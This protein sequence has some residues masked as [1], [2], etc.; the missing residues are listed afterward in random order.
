[1]PEPINLNR[2]RKQ[3][4]RAEK[5]AQAEANRALHGL[6]K[7]AK[8]AAQAEAARAARA[9]DGAKRDREA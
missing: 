9:L 4:A 1:M 6:S 5:D 3:K 7:A 8:K 2:F